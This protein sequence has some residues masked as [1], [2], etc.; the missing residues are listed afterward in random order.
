[1]SQANWPGKI[2]ELLRA[3]QRIPEGQRGEYKT[4]TAYASPGVAIDFQ[5]RF[6]LPTDVAT[7]GSAAARELAQKEGEIG[8]LLTSLRLI[9]HPEILQMVE[10]AMAVS[11]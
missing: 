3:T 2:A 4:L 8:L 6:G 9:N 11:V 1:M 7:G 10:A 5:Q